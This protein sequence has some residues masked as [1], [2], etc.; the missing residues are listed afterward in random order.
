[1]EKELTIEEKTG[2]ADKDEGNTSIIGRSADKTRFRRKV[3]KGKKQK[4]SDL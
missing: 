2:A 4:L 3:A 1:M